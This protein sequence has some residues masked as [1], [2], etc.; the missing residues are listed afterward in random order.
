MIAL[1]LTQP[2]ATLVVL[3]VKRFETRGWSPAGRALPLRL[4]VH[5]AKSWRT[6]DRWFAEELRKRGVISAGTSLPLGAVVGEA[7]VVAIHETRALR[8]GLPRLERELGDFTDGRL[9]W[10]LADS[11]VYAE[12]IAASGALG[13]WTWEREA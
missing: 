1:T 5:A 6:E 3:G 11:V 12:P 4:A 10:E 7:S 13:L 2:W 8:E 9:A